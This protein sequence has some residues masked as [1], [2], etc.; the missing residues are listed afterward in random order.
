MTKGKK[1]KIFPRYNQARKARRFSLFFCG[2]HPFPEF[3]AEDS[4]RRVK[5]KKESNQTNSRKTTRSKGLFDHTFAIGKE[6]WSYKSCRAHAGRAGRYCYVQIRLEKTCLTE[7]RSNVQFCT[8]D[9]KIRTK[10][11][12]GGLRFGAMQAEIY[13]QPIGRNGY[14]LSVSQNWIA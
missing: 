7:V 6:A 13:P 2:A 3:S 12:W 8:G 1:S 4:G 9:S 14:V 11:D 5:K 10:S